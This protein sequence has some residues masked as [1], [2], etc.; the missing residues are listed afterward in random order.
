M[1]SPPPT[2][3]DSPRFAEERRARILQALRERG[4]MEVL[5]LAKMFGVSEHTIRR[6]LKQLDAE[7]HVQKTH[8]GAVML[9]AARLDFVGR[10]EVL[11]NAKHAIGK[12][13]ADLIGPGKTLILDA[14]S[15]TL[16][17]ARSLIARPVTVIT[18]SLDI[19][20]RLERDAAVQLVLIGGTWV[21]Q[22]RALRGT[23]SREQLLTYRA[24]FAII[25]ACALDIAG[26]VTVTDEEDASVKRTMIARAAQT[27]V[28]ADHSKQRGIA[29]FKVAEWNQVQ[30]LVTDTPW[31]ELAELG[32]SV[33][34][35][36][37]A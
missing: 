22:E 18:N 5:A 31:P 30:R 32:V 23:A 20:M 15:T 1:V 7:G 36:T 37:S 33:H 26:G 10:S 2:Q 34:V 11:Q 8:G 29:P 16:A 24:D 13:A 28:L 19:A 17:L 27:M 6:D 12:A 35:S 4:R 14:G 21:K 9:D 3:S 25:G